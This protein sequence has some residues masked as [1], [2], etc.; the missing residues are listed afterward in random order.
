MPRVAI[1]TGVDEVAAEPGVAPVP[2][3]QIYQYAR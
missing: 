2:A 3:D 1:I